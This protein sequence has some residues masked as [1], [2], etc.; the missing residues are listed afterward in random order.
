MERLSVDGAPFQ[1]KARSASS[2]QAAV[3]AEPLKS[4]GGKR[5]Y[6]TAQDNRISKTLYHI[7]SLRFR[8][9]G[10]ELF[11]ECQ[12]QAELGR[13]LTQWLTAV[14]RNRR[15]GGRGL[16]SQVMRVSQAQNMKRRMAI[17]P[18]KLLRGALRSGFC[19]PTHTLQI[20]L[21]MGRIGCIGPA[22]ACF[23]QAITQQGV[24]APRV[25]P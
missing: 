12:R 2:H 18:R 8:G 15:N 1:R 3:P 10:R 13:L 22:V 20:R 17:G 14:W 9:C 4:E 19:L 21:E 6:G 25:Y 11:L 24:C 23:D 16:W 5:A 7:L